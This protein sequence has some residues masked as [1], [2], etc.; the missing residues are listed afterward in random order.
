MWCFAW[1]VRFVQ[2]KNV[3]NTHGGV[4]FLVQF[5]A[6]AFNSTKVTRFHGCF[7]RFLNYTNGAKSREVSH[8]WSRQGISSIKIQNKSMNISKFKELQGSKFSFFFIESTK[9]LMKYQK[10]LIQ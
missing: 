1:L 7:S 5:Q 8:R 10:S 9:I 6:L 3:K 2:F 4:L